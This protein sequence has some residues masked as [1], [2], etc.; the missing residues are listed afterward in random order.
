MEFNSGFKGLN[1]LVH[2]AERINLVSARVLLY[3]KCSLP[4]S[5]SSSCR[6]SPWFPKG[7]GTSKL[8]YVMGVER[9]PCETGIPSIPKFYKARDFTYCTCLLGVAFTAPRNFKY[10]Y[11]KSRILFGLDFR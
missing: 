6:C 1:G 11:P 9:I 7:V 3:F 10:F 4:F 5:D 8:S 2:F